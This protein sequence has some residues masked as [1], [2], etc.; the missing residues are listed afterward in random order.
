MA[1]TSNAMVAKG[2][3]RLE[4]L[5]AEKP[6]RLRSGA[7]QTGSCSLDQLR[8]TDSKSGAGAVVRERRG[9]VTRAAA[10]SGSDVIRLSV[11]LVRGLVGRFQVLV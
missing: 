8:C 1:A 6:S 11:G 4:G 10:G 9:V 5:R 7:W 3:V 2:A